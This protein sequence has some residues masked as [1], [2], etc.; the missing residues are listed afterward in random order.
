MVVAGSGPRAVVTTASYEARRYG[1]GSAMPAARARRLCP[2]AVFL[3]PD[4]PTYREV[5]AR[6]MAIVRAHVERVEVVGLDEAYLDL[7]GPVLAA[8][9][10]APAGGRDPGRDA[11]SPARSGIGPNKLV[12]KVASDAEKP[13]GFVVLTREQA[14]ARF[15]SSPPGLVPGIGP[16]TAERLAGARADDAGA[17][18]R[19]RPRTLLVERFG[20]NLGRELARRARF[21]HDGE[22][23]AAAQ[24]RIRVAGADLRPG[25][26]RPRRAARGALGG[27]PRSCARASPPTGAR[28]RTIA[29]KVRLDDFT[30]VTRA[31][32]VAE[33]TC[34]AELV[35]AQALRLLERVRPAAARAAARRARGRARGRRRR[36]A[37]PAA[38]ARARP[39]ARSRA[40]AAGVPLP[41]AGRIAG[42]PIDRARERSQLDYER[43]GSGPPLLLIM[44]MS[45]TALHWG[46]PFLAAL[47]ERLRGDRLRPPRGRRQQP[48]GGPSSRSPRW[49]TTRPALLAALEL[50]SAHV[51]GISMGGMVAQEL[52]L[53]HPERVRTLTLGCTYCGGPGSSLAAPAVLQRLSEAMVSGD[54]ERA[55]RAGWEVNVSPARRR[56][57]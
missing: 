44:G 33:P 12:A 28:G 11:G 55:I 49:P 4:F 24:G 57:R 15:A 22:V 13:A 17:R 18:W 26:Q 19:R 16:K 14:C 36:A 20:P 40:G 31:H 39:T 27:W 53:G 30:T 10:D 46:E 23:S 56:R 51:L 42:M 47:R 9:G 45:G 34:D 43:S 38:R 50:D 48:P 52:A 6:M 5:S 25:H 7:D 32:T 54:R 3:A 37:A 1:V 41:A 8:R 2:E 29:I 35:T 21:E